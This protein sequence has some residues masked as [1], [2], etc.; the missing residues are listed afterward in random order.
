MNDTTL[1]ARAIR[2]DVR[3][4]KQERILQRAQSLFYERGFRGTSLEAIA[5]SMGVT[6]PFVYGIYSRKV[7]ILF[8]LLNRIAGAAADTVESACNERGTPTHRLAQ[9]ARRLTKVCLAHQQGVA[10]SFREDG[11]LEHAQLKVIAAHRRRI[12]TALGQLLQDG[13][14]VREFDVPNPAVAVRA[15]GGMICWTFT[16]YRAGSTPGQESQLQEEMARNALRIAGV[17]DFPGD[18]R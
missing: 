3:V 6:K 14:A 5:E 1:Q 15:I 17:L 10:V 11:A 8:D 2:D 4:L 13:T 9:A 7:D 12:D 16:W 18:S